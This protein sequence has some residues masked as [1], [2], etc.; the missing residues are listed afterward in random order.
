MT[1]L[2]CCTVHYPIYKT[3]YVSHTY[4]VSESH[5]AVITI[6]TTVHGFSLG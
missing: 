6:A 1:A 3:P 2:R 4:G 5:H